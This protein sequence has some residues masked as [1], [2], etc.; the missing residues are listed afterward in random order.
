MIKYVGLYQICMAEKK[1]WVIA[2]TIYLSNFCKPVYKVVSHDHLK[3]SFDRDHLDKEPKWKAALYSDECSHFYPRKLL[4]P[5]PGPLIKHGGA[6]GHH[7]IF[8]T[9]WKALILSSLSTIKVYEIAV[10]L[11]ECDSFSRL[12]CILDNI[13]QYND[14]SWLIFTQ[15]FH[16]PVV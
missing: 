16:V 5:G 6:F 4:H 12:R 15:P 8:G 9:N 14:A 13:N 1:V 11:V 3:R 7:F 10:I 2:S